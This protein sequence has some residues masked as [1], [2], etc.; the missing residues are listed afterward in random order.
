MPRLILVRQ[1]YAIPAFVIVAS[2]VVGLRLLAVH[3]WVDPMFDLHAYWS[4]RDGLDYAAPPGALGAYLYS[5]A[6]AQAIAPITALPWPLFAAIWTALLFGCLWWIAGRAAIV[7]LL[8]FPPVAFG[9]V[10]GQVDLIMVAAIVLGFRLPAAWVVPILMKATP[11]VGLVWFLVRREW[12]SLW[13]ACAATIGVVGLSA[14][15][16]PGAWGRWLELLRGAVLHP[17]SGGVQLEIPVVVRLAVSAGIIAWGART[18]RRWTVPI[19]VVFAMPILWLQ[20]LALLVAILPLV[21]AGR[22]TPAGRWLREGG[23]IG[24]TQVV[25]EW[26]RRS[27]RSRRQVPLARPG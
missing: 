15:L 22:A 10:F 7:V 27:R 17:L 21:A 25:V 14:A 8:A 18:D 3:P 11:G 12:R 2:L 1:R 20:T 24:P 13:L 4:T 9:L 23:L 19:G 16:D 5:P 6:F 26:L